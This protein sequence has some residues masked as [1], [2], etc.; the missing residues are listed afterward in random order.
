MVFDLTLWTNDP[1]LAGRA[2]RAGV[3][4]IGPDLE[5]IGKAARQSGRNTWISPHR[6]GDIENVRGS[7]SCAELFCRC[8]PYGDHT[9][10]ELE[11][12]V[13]MGV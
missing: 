13:A 11:R 3:D 12:L 8:N 10:D 1:D 9:P 6:E 5:W 2:D 4:R 7:L